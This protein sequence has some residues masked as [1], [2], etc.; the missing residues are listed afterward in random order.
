MHVTRSLLSHGLGAV[1]RR[2]LHLKGGGVIVATRLCLLVQPREE[3]IVERVLRQPGENMLWLLG[4]PGERLCCVRLCDGCCS[5]SQE[6][7][8][9]SRQ[10]FFQPLSSRLA[11]PGFSKQRGQCEQ[12][13]KWPHEQDEEQRAA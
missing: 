11:Y 8:N 9:V 7:I 2:E 1:H 13:D 6:R 12:Q 3:R 10:A 4:Q 5:S